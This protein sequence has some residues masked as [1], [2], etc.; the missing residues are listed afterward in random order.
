MNRQASNE[1]C[2]PIFF[3][4]PSSPGPLQRSSIPVLSNKRASTASSEDNSSSLNFASH[5]TNNVGSG[6]YAATPS[7]GRRTQS[8]L[9]PQQRSTSVASN[10]TTQVSNVMSRQLLEEANK[11]PMSSRGK[12][13]SNIQQQMQRCKTTPSHLVSRNS[14]GLHRSSTTTPVSAKMSGRVSLGTTLSD[15]RP[16]KLPSMTV[17]Q[18][19]SRSTSPSGKLTRL[20]VRERGAQPSRPMSSRAGTE[21][22]TTSHLRVSRIPRSQGHSRESSRNA[23]RDGS[24]SRSSA[25]SERYSLTVLSPRIFPDGHSSIGTPRKITLL[26]GRL[27]EN[28]TDMEQT[29]DDALAGTLSL[30][31]DEGASETSSISSDISHVHS[32]S[33]LNTLEIIASMSSP[34][35]SERRQG[36]VSLQLLMKSNGY[37]N[38]PELKRVTDIF[39]RMFHEPKSKVF[40]TFLETLVEVIEVHAEEMNDWLYACLSRLLIKLAADLLGSV[41]ARIHKA[42]QAICNGFSFESQ[43]SSIARFLAEQSLAFNLRVRLAILDHLHSLM[44][45]SEPHEFEDSESC[46]QV[47][48]CVVQWTNEPKSSEIRKAAKNV[49]VALFNLNTPEFSAVLSKLPR[50][51]QDCATRILHQH[52][53]SVS[54]QMEANID[55]KLTSRSDSNDQDEMSTMTSEDYFSSLKKT[56][57]D[58]QSLS[59]LT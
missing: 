13:H 2:S 31:R 7:S 40:S 34:S 12:T 45:L 35:C 8:I 16:S 37:L 5:L 4:T 57:E 41:Q 46:R 19:G 38:S 20:A 56:A 23:S 44:L 29:L 36:L 22:P 42:L 58:I 48:L 53:Y 24:P 21:R 26:S 1:E 11:L 52:M 51:I 15:R 33:A 25:T 3:K 30:Q 9:T 54:Q 39:T 27:L 17:S 18:P 49:V 50:S 43:L 32:N 6:R 47:A 55:I 28:G 10:G 59:F 14:D